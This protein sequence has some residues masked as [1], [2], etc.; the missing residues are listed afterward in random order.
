V[1]ADYFRKDH[2]PLARQ[3][4]AHLRGLERIISSKTI[5]SVY[6]LPK[7]GASHETADKNN[8]RRYI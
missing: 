8:D 5:I 1:R 7:A 3:G 4:E 6:T 2:T